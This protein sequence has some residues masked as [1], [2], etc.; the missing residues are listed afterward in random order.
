M[1]DLLVIGWGKG[2]KTLA[3]ILANKGKKVAIIEK[4]PKMYGGTCPNVGCLPT[5]AMVHRAKILSEM[6][7]LGVERDYE[8]NNIIYQN[9]LSEK[10]KLVNKVNTANFNLLNNNEN[11]TVYNG[12]AKFIS[13]TEVM[14]NGEILTAKNIVIN[15][16]SKTRIPNIK[17][18]E[19]KHVLTSDDG[20][21]L[22]I[23]PK[24]L[25]IIGGG[26]IGI[27][28]ASYFSNF[29]SDVTVFEGIDKFMPKE[30][31]DIS[32]TIFNILV[33][34]GINFNFG[35]K[36]LEFNE[37]EDSIE[38]KFE[39]DGEIKSEIFD[40]ILISIGREPN[41]EG[42]DLENTNITVS[43]RGEVVVNEYLET[44]V[45][46]IY[47]VGD[48]K[49]GEMFTAVSLDDSRIILPQ[50]LGEKGRS[51]VSGRNVPKVLFIDPSYAQVG[52]NEK[53]ATEKGIKYIVKKLA[54]TAIP[55]SL[56]IGETDGFTKVLI[57]EN[58]EII[59]AFIINYEAHE[60]INLLALAIDQKIKYQVL[61]DLIYSHPVFTEGLNDILK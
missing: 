26:F 58:D 22:E 54:T 29:G 6:E 15:T 36:I 17:G 3:G 12:E 4:D 32:E 16:G 48:V 43:D 34:Q 8:F 55:K 42:L 44:T 5:K 41:I 10:K 1:Y 27:E 45:K 61:R 21:E 52:L 40:K 24:K 9:A 13:N 53:Q 7:L 19:S 20:L 33:E 60:M 31:I 49:G 57:N 59:G 25:A 39:K 2:G 51:L 14:V 35:I 46:G 38:I 28:F 37:V 47:A 56:V 30:D 23:L 11:V 18:V 50:I